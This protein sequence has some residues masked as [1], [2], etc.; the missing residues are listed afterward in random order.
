[1]LRGKAVFSRAVNHA[2]P[3][4]VTLAHAPVAHSL[5]PTA[6][7]EQRAGSGLDRGRRDFSNGENRTRRKAKAGPDPLEDPRGE[8]EGEGK[9]LRAGRRKAGKALGRTELGW[10]SA[11]CLTRERPVSDPL[12]A[13][14]TF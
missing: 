4:A 12:P 14:R 5:T 13:S 10:W 11:S 6:V 1:M 8:R 3:G 2:E 7:A 9:A